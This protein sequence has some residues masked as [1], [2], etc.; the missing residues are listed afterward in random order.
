V[1]DRLCLPRR[2]DSRRAA[3]GARGHCPSCCCLWR[4][5]ARWPDDRPPSLRA[6]SDR[7]VLAHAVAGW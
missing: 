3:T 4:P 5:P 6:P 7:P 1:D 2:T